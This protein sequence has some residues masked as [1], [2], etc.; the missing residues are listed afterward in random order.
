MNREDALELIGRHV[1]NENSIKHML[2][3]EAVMRALAVRFGEDEERWGLTGLLH[4][5]DMEIVDYVADPEE[6]GKEGAAILE[7]EGVDREIAEA[8]R[9]HNPATGKRP[10]TMMEK[11]IYCADPLTGLIVASTL[12][13]PSR[14]IS[15]LTPV[16]VMN[17]YKERAFARGADRETIASCSEM[18]LELEEFISIGLEAMKGIAGK[19]GF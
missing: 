15:D 8:V 14:K 1:K 19:L 7:E 17:R 2:A 3:A 5:I 6:H 16:S 9:A 18:G 4:D 11:A 10:E 12:V 13:L